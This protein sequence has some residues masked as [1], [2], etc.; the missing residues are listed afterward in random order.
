[1]V[2]KQLLRCLLLAGGLATLRLVA[3][4]PVPAPRVVS[5]GELVRR[6]ASPSEQE[7]QEARRQLLLLE[8]EPPE[9]LRATESS[10]PLQR[11][12][13]ANV[14]SKMAQSRADRVM[15]RAERYVNSGQIDL[16]VANSQMWTLATGEERLWMPAFELSERIAA[17]G[18][19]QWPLGGKKASGVKGFVTWTDPTFVRTDEPFRPQA[20]IGKGNRIPCHSVGIIAPEIE[21]PN[22]IY[23][24]FLVS[25][26]IVRTRDNISQSV[27]I[28]N[29]DVAGYTVTN[30][31]I[32][33]DGDITITLATDTILI[34][35]GKIN[36]A[37]A[38]GSHLSVGETIKFRYP[39][40]S[41][42]DPNLGNTA[43]E[44]ETKH[45]GFLTFF[46][47]SRVGLEVTAKDKSL[48]IAK[49]TDGSPLRKA[50]VAV[51]DVIAKANGVFVTTAEELRRALRDAH[52]RSRR[53]VDGNPRPAPGVARPHF[54]RKRTASA[55]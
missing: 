36:T 25:R 23:K 16:L 47:L 27:V 19:L 1:M 3:A 22:S 38:T 48:R 44:S 8:S 4:E 51:D 42:G 21:S 52:R 6:L 17:K 26:G 46:E 39:G 5:P 31:I 18:K 35:R 50:G 53:E 40:M 37:A 2:T 54:R 24:A 29:G 15:N 45:L 55:C 13:A 12:R 9:L 20:R 30:A 10:D 11:E 28:A 41:P 14:L 32:I 34:A 43:K 49:L 33:A 7:W